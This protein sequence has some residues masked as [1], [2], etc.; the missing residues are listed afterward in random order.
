MA[1]SRS[2]M[3]DLNIKCRS[4]V[5]SVLICLHSG[6]TLGVHWSFNVFALFSV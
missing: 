6:L 2:N 1:G 4:I 3:N 5:C